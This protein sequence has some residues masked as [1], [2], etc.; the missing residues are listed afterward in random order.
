[1]CHMNSV[2][3]HFAKIAAKHFFYE[4]RDAF[5]ILAHF[6]SLIPFIGK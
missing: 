6:I 2:H 1:M 3:E 4:C 5:C